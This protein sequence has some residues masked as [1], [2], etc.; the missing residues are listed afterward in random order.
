MASKDFKWTLYCL[1]NPRRLLHT[2]TH[3]HSGKDASR[4]NSLS[5]QMET[6][7]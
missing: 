2:H 4:G 3:A 7:V 1:K 6:G 5:P